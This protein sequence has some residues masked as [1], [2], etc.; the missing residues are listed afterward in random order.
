[1]NE[2]TSESNKPSKSIYLKF[3]GLVEGFILGACNV[4]PFTNTR[5]L[6]NCMRIN[7][8]DTEKN[9]GKRMGNYLLTRWPLL[10][11]TILGLIFVFLIPFSSLY[12]NIPLGFNGSMLVFCAVFLLTE[13]ISLLK[14]IHKI[15][16]NWLSFLLSLIIPIGLMLGMYFADFSF[17]GELTTLSAYAL[18][19]F[20]FLIGGFLSQF[21]GISVFTLIYLGGLFFVFSDKLNL[22]S[23]LSGIKENIFFLLGIAFGFLSGDIIAF[24]VKGRRNFSLEKTGI[25]ISF[26]LF[27]VIYLVLTKIKEPYFP[28]YSPSADADKIVVLA[29]LLGSFFIA[30]AKVFH[31]NPFSVS[32]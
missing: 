5:L 24:Y 6:K 19:V 14:N 30:V 7:E 23:Y 13:L 29:M 11:G 22:L 3:V 27:G 17:V 20:L 2:F 1:M 4:I 8:S 9:N 10:L 31:P 32:I 15:S 26:Y 16:K 28:T 18:V 25:N 12:P 21:S